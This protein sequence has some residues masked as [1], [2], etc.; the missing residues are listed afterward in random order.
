MIARSVCS[1]VLLLL[2]GNLSRAQAPSGRHVVVVV[3]DGMRPDFISEKTT[4]N[5]W[6]LAQRG[7]F[8]SNHHPVY[9]SSTEVN[10]TAIATGAYP[11]HSTLIGN[12]EFRPGIDPQMASAMERAENIRKGDKLGEPGYIAVQTVAEF[13]HAHSVRTAIA[14][15]KPVALLGDR[16]P[17][18]NSPDSSPVI[19]DG[20]ALPP[21]TELNVAA[22]LGDNP[23]PAPDG[24]TAKPNK[25][26][27]D[28]WTTR[29]LTEVLWKDGVPAYSLLWLSEPDFSQHATGPG[30]AQSLAA[31]RSSDENL[32]RVISEIGRRGLSE[33]T[34][35][36]VVS[37]HGFSTVADVADV[38]S[39]LSLAGF[40]SARAALGGLKN[41]QILVVSN[42]G[43]AFLYVGGHDPELVRKVAFW[44]QTQPW[45]GV[46]FSK[47]G[48]PGT[49]GL[50][51][52]KIAS[53]ESP[54]LV[55]SMRWNL[56]TNSSGAPGLI[57]ADASAYGKGQGAHASLCP[58]EMHNTLVAAGPDFKRGVRDPFPSGNV[59]VAPTALWILGY[60]AEA[61]RRDGRVLGEAMVGEAPGLKTFETRRIVASRDT[62]GGVWSE[63]LLVSEVNGVRYLDEGNGAFNPVGK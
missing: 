36:L 48:I 53:V 12:V 6:M 58:T 49:I 33:S 44:A 18:P 3:W 31:I 25:I 1:V 13:L 4:P 47:A 38:A 8:F 40:S 35:L 41:G 52:A 57:Y 34:D 28:A 39:E 9:A 14:G 20:S 27:K 63:Y 10:G 11:E 19:Y 5:L 32:G 30:S 2:A 51:E 42:V 23:A 22:A 55:V 45:A 24:G 54:D 61:L 17:R 43:A 50:E 15:A 37:D 59:D 46:V 62:V 16:M 26:S 29:A 21:I 7:V 60:H 56:G